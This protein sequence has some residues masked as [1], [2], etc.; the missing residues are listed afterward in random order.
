[1]IKK[2]TKILIIFSFILLSNCGFKVLDT[3]QIN[4]FTIQEIKTTGDKRTSFKIKNNLIIN[5]EKNNKNILIINLDTKK[6]RSIKEKN[7][8]NEITK[9][10]ISLEITVEFN[11]IGSDINEKFNINISGDYLVGT[12]YSTTINNEKKLINNLAENISTNILNR[13]GSKINDI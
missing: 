5:S 8:K 1:M 2:F 13:I 7:I 4:N 12:N 11:L 3:S 6:E 9:Y 10:E